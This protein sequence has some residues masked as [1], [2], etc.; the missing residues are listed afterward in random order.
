MLIFLTGGPILENG[1]QLVGQSF[2]LALACLGYAVLTF[3]VWLAFYGKLSGGVVAW[4]LIVW[5]GVG[6]WIPAFSLMISG[7][8]PF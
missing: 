8:L 1:A 3:E 4:S 7:K 5:V 2:Y 6:L